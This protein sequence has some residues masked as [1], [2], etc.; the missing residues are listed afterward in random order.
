MTHKLD[1]DDFFIHRV[2]QHC[3]ERGLNF[4]LVEPLF[5]ERFHECFSRKEIWARVLLNMHSEHHLPEDIYSRVV[6]LAHERGTKVID[7]PAKAEAAF[8]KSRMHQRLGQAGFR[9][10]YTLIVPAGDVAGF[11]LSAEEKA[12][13]GE[14]FVVKPSHGYGRKGVILDARDESDLA[15]SVKA[16]LNPAYLL[17]ERICPKMDGEVPFYFRVFYVFGRVWCCWWNCFTDRYKEVTGEERERFA[18]GGLEEIVRGVAR[19]S[20]MT[21]F[22]SEIALTEAG[23]FVLIDYVNDQCHM[24]SQSADPKMGVPDRVVAGVARALVEGAFAERQAT[25]FLG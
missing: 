7:E 5:V 15:A 20:E 25:H 14:R 24:L 2:Q 12:R 8:D 6:R 16:W 11:K 22:S 13:L 4:F 3:A 23:E 18:L 9:V 1:A 19:L 21:F 10:P 17:Q